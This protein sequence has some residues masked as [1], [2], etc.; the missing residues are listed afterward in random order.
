[1][2]SPIAAGKHPLETL[3]GR[4]VNGFR[5]HL[6]WGPESAY[7]AQYFHLFIRDGRGRRS[8]QP[9]VTGL[10]N[11]GSEPA[12]NWIEIVISIG[13]VTIDPGEGGQE[14]VQISD[15]MYRHLFRLLCRL[16]P[17]GGHFMI[18]YDSP[19]WL[20]TRQSL[21]AG[22]PPLATPLG[23]LLFDAGCGVYIKDW[24]LAEGGREGW[25]KLLC[26]NAWDESHA[27]AR[28]ADN[29]RELRDYL[30]RKPRPGY[31]APER[32]ARRRARRILKKLS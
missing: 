21:A 19:R 30:G 24:D 25:R 1:M 12:Y 8:V 5:L 14:S 23:S 27:R 20:T 9:V 10:F 18:E 31:E 29:I 28:A 32:E 16:L 26:Y 4:K 3:N 17:P 13:R 15:P 6:V 7:G 11:S 22:I 2:S